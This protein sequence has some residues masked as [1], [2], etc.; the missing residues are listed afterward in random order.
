MNGIAVLDDFVEYKHITISPGVL[1]QG[2]TNDRG[3]GGV[4]A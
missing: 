3:S 4:R 1:S 2:R